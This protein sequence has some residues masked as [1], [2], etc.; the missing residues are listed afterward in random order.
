[1]TT[2]AS[3]EAVGAEEQ[4]SLAK[5]LGIWAVVALPMLLITYVIAPA[6]IPR[7][8]LNPGILFWFLT[9]LGMAWQFVVSMIVLYRELGTLRWS[10]IGKRM[11]YQTP[12]DPKTSEPKARLF[13]WS[14]PLILLS[15]GLGDM[16]LRGPLTTAVL[17][18]L[19]ALTPPSFTDTSGL[20]SPEFVGQ[21]WLLGVVLISNAFNYFLGE[22]FLFRGVLL[23]KM[24]GVFGKWD[25]VMNA[26]LFAAYHLH[27]PQ[28]I[29]PNILITAPYIW[30]CKHFRSN[31]FGVIVHGVGGVIMF[32]LVFLVVSGMAF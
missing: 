2:N 23:P 31:W 17:R 11:W 24:E 3:Q 1:M 10:V 25:W 18:F 6:L 30:A 12:R 9:I 4:Y 26:V 22:E 15:V 20:A 29:L 19:P 21:W 27:L 16:V 32:V 7:V 8:N 28:A 5:I 13:W 14:V